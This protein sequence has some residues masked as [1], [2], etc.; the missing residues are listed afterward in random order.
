ME[1][2]I[3]KPFKGSPD[4]YTIID[5]KQGDT[6]DHAEMGDSLVKA[7]LAEKWIKPSKAADKEAKA[8]AKAE[9][10]ARANAEAEADKKAAQHRA[11]AIAVIEGEIADLEAQLAAASE[12]DKPSI[13]SALEAKQ[14]EFAAL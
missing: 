12:E 1:Y 4:G 3:I 13:Q 14:N 7:A 8:K 5:F 6:V 9:A 10:E 2:E 11:D